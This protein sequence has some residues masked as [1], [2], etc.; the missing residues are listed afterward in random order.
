MASVSSH[1]SPHSLTYDF[2]SM[3]DDESWQ[4]LEYSSNASAPGSVG[5]LPSP[6]SG[7]LDGFALVERAHWTPP[8]SASPLS[9][10]DV[11]QTVFLPGES[12]LTGEAARSS[13][14]LLTGGSTAMAADVA[15]SGG[16]P[17]VNPEDYFFSGIEELD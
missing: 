8:Q 11:D 13:D 17:F 9:L 7:S 4:H 1:T 16:M 14:H 6:A 15:D 10:V 12:F 2:E 5:F 3:G